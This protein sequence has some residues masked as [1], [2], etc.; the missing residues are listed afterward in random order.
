DGDMGELVFT[1]LT[2]EA[3]PIIRYR[4][5]DL[6]RLL[7][8]TAR[9]MRR[10]EKVTGRSDDM[11]ILRGVNVFPT[12]IEECLMATPG[13]APHFQIELTKPDRMDQMCVL[14]EAT[15]TERDG[16]AK[17]LAARIKQTI[18][19]SVK[20]NVA[21]PGG[22]ARSEGKAVRILDRR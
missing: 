8:G 15:G 17:A 10:M 14:A 20:V 2:K 22:V 9:S 11:I 16:P 18:G 6:T 5:R 12:Q 19:I 4:T 1:S 13:L 3:F 7:P 21:D